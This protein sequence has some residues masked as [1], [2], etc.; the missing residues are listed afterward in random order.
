[1]ARDTTQPESERVGMSR[2]GSLS[3]MVMEFLEGME[4]E[5]CGRKEGA[6][7]EYEENDGSVANLEEEEIF[8]SSQHNDLQVSPGLESI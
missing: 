5:R 4:G 2:K 8:W 6:E 3:D 7:S 1:M